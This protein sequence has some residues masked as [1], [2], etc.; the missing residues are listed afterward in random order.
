MLFLSIIIVTLTKLKLGREV[1][2]SGVES[3]EEESEESEELLLI[4]KHRDDTGLEKAP[5][6]EKE[7]EANENEENEE[8]EDEKD[9]AED[10]A[11]P[12][13]AAQRQRSAADYFGM[14]ISRD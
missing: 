9:K 2:K 7:D 14:L 10:E 8:E 5:R 3:A 4:A 13:L 6:P 11:A 1:T 12:M